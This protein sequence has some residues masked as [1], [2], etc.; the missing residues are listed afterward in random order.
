MVQAIIAQSDRPDLEPVILNEAR[1]EIQD[2]FLSSEKARRVLGWR[3]KHTLQD[4]LRKTIGWYREF[5]SA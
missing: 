3:P 1:N 4:G 2:Q 5:L